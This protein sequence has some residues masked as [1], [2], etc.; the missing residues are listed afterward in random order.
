MSKTATT[1]KLPMTADRFRAIKDAAAQ[2]K[3]WCCLSEPQTNDM[4]FVVYIYDA[5]DDYIDS[6]FPKFASLLMTEGVKPS[7][8]LPWGKKHMFH[9]AIVSLVLG[10]ARVCHISKM[11]AINSVSAWLYRMS[12]RLQA[13]MDPYRW[14]VRR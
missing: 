10:M 6:Q 11:D 12:N 1:I 4:R 5:K 13:G 8:P 7:N 9:N 2:K 3:L 14:D